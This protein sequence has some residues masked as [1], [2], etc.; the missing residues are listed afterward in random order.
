VSNP[1][2]QPNS[3]GSYLGDY[4]LYLNGMLSVLRGNPRDID[5]SLVTE[6]ESE[7]LELR[8]YLED[9]DS[10]GDPIPSELCTIVGALESIDTAHTA[11][12]A[13]IEVFED[14]N[15]D[16]VTRTKSLATCYGDCR[17]AL[18]RALKHW[19]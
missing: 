19:R 9:L 17:N 15:Y 8:N 4:K 14:E 11:M 5:Q 12:W 2:S 13:A 3:S 18:R 7:L 16:T 10:N 1:R 6:Y